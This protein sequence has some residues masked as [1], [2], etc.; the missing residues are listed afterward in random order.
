MIPKWDKTY[1]IH[2]A[3]LD[4]QH[5]ELFKLAEKLEFI[6][7]KPIHKQEIKDLLTDFFHYIKTHFNEEE[8]YMKMI[9]YPDFKN[10]RRHHREINH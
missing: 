2:N 5:Q 7:D 9:N 6:Y 4:E 10:H 1:S 8:K 3:K